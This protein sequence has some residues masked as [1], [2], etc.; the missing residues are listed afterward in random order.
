MRHEYGGDHNIL[1]HIKKYYMIRK[2]N[3][4]FSV[5]FF[6]YIFS[7]LLIKSMKI[8]RTKQQNITF[9]IIQQKIIINKILLE[10]TSNFFFNISSLMNFRSFNSF[11]FTVCRKKKSKSN[12]REILWMYE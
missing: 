9:K 12:R 1:L 3:I 11:Y 2:L 6:L 5:L 8:S 7:I 4:N 10:T